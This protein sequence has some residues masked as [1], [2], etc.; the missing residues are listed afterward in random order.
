MTD[1]VIGGMK[2]F[3]PWA[4]AVAAIF[5]GLVQLVNGYGSKSATTD[6][7]TAR[8]ERLEQDKADKRE[9]DDVKNWLRGMN[10]K[11]DRVLENQRKK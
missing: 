8:I 6:T 2:G 5:L 7:N 9:M 3:A 4:G 1:K 10:D 11:I